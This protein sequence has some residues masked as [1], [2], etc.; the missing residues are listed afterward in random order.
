MLGTF[1]ILFALFIIGTKGKRSPI[2]ARYDSI[3]IQ[4]G[5]Y[6]FFDTRLSFNNTKSCGSCHDPE[7]AFTDGYR[8]SITASGEQLKHNAPSLVNAVFLNYFDWANP[9]VTSLE[10]QEQRPLFNEHPKELGARGF[11]TIILKRLK[12]DSIYKKLFTGAFPG[13]KEPISFPSVIRSIAAFVSTIKSLNSPF[14]RF[15]KGD[16]AALTR[17]AQKGMELFFSEK[18]QCKSCHALPL[19]TLATNS[20]ALDSIYINTGLYNIKNKNEYPSADNG[21]AAFTGNENDDGK[22][23]IPTLRNISITA[24]YMHDG[25]INSLE[26]VI[27]VYANGGRNIPSGTFAGDGRINNRKDKRIRRFDLSKTERKQLIDFLFSLTDS[28]VLINPAFLNPFN[29][30][31]K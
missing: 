17:S 31:N 24:P 9:S 12:E 8:T 18:L 15:N 29:I 5:H 21:L 1:A 2:A 28:A 20:R 27:D 13:L 10:K 3:L 7:F 22:F 4:T 11:E 14:D 26:E 16:S 19:F 6:L 25:S 23:K 30:S